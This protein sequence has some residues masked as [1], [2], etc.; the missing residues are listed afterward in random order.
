MQ[1]R[2]SIIHSLDALDQAVATEK[3]NFESISLRTIYP[4]DPSRYSCNIWW[5]DATEWQRDCH[6]RHVVHLEYSVGPD[7]YDFIKSYGRGC[8]PDYP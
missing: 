4:L 5:L 1:P 3:E 7:Q 8:A 2:S 6:W